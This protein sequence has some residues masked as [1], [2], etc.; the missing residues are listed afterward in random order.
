MRKPRSLPNPYRCLR[1]A[2]ISLASLIILLSLAATEVALCALLGR[3]STMCE[4]LTAPYE[5]W[6]LATAAGGI[7]YTL[8]AAWRDFFKGRYYSDLAEVQQH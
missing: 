2:G 8:Y 5:W 4:A 7:A 6:L 3:T 1:G